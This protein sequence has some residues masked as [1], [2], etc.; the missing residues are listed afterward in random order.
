MNNCDFFKNE[1]IIVEGQYFFTAHP[2]GEAMAMR[3]F[4]IH[5]S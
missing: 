1:Y 4:K 5:P 3:Q 2:Q